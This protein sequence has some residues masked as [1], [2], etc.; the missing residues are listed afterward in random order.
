ML[1][2]G[3]DAVSVGW[4]MAA[5]L[6]GSEPVADL[7]AGIERR[8]VAGLFEVSQV[9]SPWDVETPRGFVPGVNTVTMGRAAHGEPDD[10]VPPAQAPPWRAGIGQR[11]TSRSGDANL[12]GDHGPGRASRGVRTPIESVDCVVVGGGPA[13]LA[14]ANYDLYDRSERSAE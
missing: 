13:G 12:T 1:S 4:H 3:S 8:D 7:P 11:M 14:A 6:V 2:S 10:R 5:S 9:R